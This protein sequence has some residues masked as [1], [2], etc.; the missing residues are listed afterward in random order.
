M[1]FDVTRIGLSNSCR[2]EEMTVVFE[3][4]FLFDIDICKNRGNVID[5]TTCHKWGV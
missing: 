1:L 2:G 4:V 3:I 5:I